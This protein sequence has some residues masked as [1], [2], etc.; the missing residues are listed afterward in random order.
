M[1]RTFGQRTLIART[2][3]CLTLAGLKLRGPFRVANA[4]TFGTGATQGQHSH[5]G[6]AAG[7]SNA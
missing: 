3:R 4:Q 5:S 1:K 7:Q 2:F 6:A